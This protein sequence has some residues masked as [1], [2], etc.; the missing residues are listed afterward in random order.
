[1]T[2]LLI[3]TFALSGLHTILWLPRALQM[4]RQRNAARAQQ[5]KE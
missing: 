1:M 5:K 4:R 3:G 2:G